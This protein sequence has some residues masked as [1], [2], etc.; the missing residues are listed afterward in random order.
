[1]RTSL[2]SGFVCLFFFAGCTS[3]APMAPEPAPL[4]ETVE[5]EVPTAVDDPVP[6]V[7]EPPAPTESYT[8]LSVD[9][10]RA[11]LKE[12]GIPYSQRSFL[13]AAGEG[14][15]PLVRLFVE[16]GMNIRAQNPDEG[17]DTAL[18]RAAGEG[19]LPV[20][21]YLVSQDPESKTKHSS[22]LLDNGRC[23]GLLAMEL[24]N[25]TR[26]TACNHQT[27]LVMAAWG[28]HVEVIRY[29][30]GHRA[31]LAHFGWFDP[32]NGP[33][34]AMELAAFAGHLEAVKLLRQRVHPN[35]K[36]YLSNFGAMAWA[37]YQG[38]LPVVRY[39]FN[40]GVGLNPRRQL[41]RS[42]GHAITQLMFAAWG[43]QAEVVRF[44]L[45]NGADMFIIKAQWFMDEEGNTW[46]ELGDN[47]LTL[48]ITYSHDEVVAI[49]LDHWVYTHGLDGRDDSGRTTLMYAAWGGN[50]EAMQLFLDG[51]VS[52]NAQTNVGS[53]ALMF[54][55]SGGN[56]EAVRLLLAWGADPT[57]QNAYGHT[58]LGIAQER[59]HTEIAELLEEAIEEAVGNE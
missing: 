21:K 43:G 25:P 35:Y 47:A 36:K 19:H 6:D 22:I 24:E 34:S 10:A 32:H 30:T 8:P 3:Q 52:V 26:H 9:Q 31:Y 54:A 7:V 23:A 18:M 55:A 53:T 58:A 40:Q 46:K 5:P 17:Y 27:A 37:S 39:F 51:G 59:G 28:G 20:V 12:R 45:A 33:D 44:L 56:V 57:V 14:D 42:R 38:H 41:D 4:V 2:A 16:A 13:G 29:L 50:T 11:Q 1:M 49:L 15:L 48:A